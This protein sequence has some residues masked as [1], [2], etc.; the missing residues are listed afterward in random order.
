[1]SIQNDIVRGDTF[2]GEFQI[3]G[4]PLLMPDGSMNPIVAASGANPCVLTTQ[5]PHSLANGQKIYID[6]LHQN[7]SV[8]GNQVATVIDSTHFSVPVAGNAN[9][10]EKGTV[11]QTIDATSFTIEQAWL[12]YVGADA[13]SVSPEL[14]WIDRTVFHGTITVAADKTSTID[15]STKKIQEM[16]RWTDSSNNVTTDYIELSIGDE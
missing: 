8:C 16:I 15:E 3:L 13:L 7:P 12:E 14:D 11:Y 6:G 10:T 4:S 9:A 1:M 5:Y 2:I